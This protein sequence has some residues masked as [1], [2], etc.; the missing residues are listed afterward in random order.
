MSQREMEEY[1]RITQQMMYAFIRKRYKFSGEMPREW[2]EFTIIYYGIDRDD[3][4]NMDVFIPPGFDDG[5]PVRAIYDTHMN[6]I[7]RFYNKI[8]KIVN[9]FGSIT[10]NN[11]NLR[12]R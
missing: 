4:S 5:I 10:E 3:V 6:I 7:R 2:A 9:V 1:V 8:T 11:N 12:R